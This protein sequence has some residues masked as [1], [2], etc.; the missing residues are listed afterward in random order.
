[1]ASF[2][3]RVIPKSKTR[4]VSRRGDALVVRVQNAPEKGKANNEAIKALAEY[5]GVASSRL[6]LVSGKGS[7]LKRVRFD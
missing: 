1:M 2:S 6:T 4:S 3:I 7:R 5:L